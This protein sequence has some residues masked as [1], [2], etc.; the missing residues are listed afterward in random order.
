MAIDVW[1]KELR[2]LREKPER[3]IPSGR[4]TPQV[5]DVWGEELSVLRGREIKSV[6]LW[7]KPTRSFMAGVGDTLKTAGYAVD[8]LGGRG[9]WAKEAG[10]AMIKKW[11]VPDGDPREFEWDNLVDPH[12]L[13]TRIPRALPFS[14]SLVPAALV[15]AAGAVKVG[16]PAL[17]AAGVTKATIAKRPFIKTLLGSLGAGAASRPIESALEAGSTYEMALAKGDTEEEAREAAKETFR[18]NL[19]LAGMDAAQIGLAFTP[20]GKGKAF[21][22]TF[23][24]R[25][26]ATTAKVAGVGSLEA[27]EEIIQDVIQRQALGEEVKWD[28]QMREAAALGAIMGCGLGSAGSVYNVLV[29]KV[30]RNLPLYQQNQIRAAKE[31]LT[32][33]EAQ[34]VEMFELDKVVETE[35]GRGVVEEAVK[36]IL[37][38]AEEFDAEHAIPV[39]RV[40]EMV[41]V[42]VESVAKEVLPAIEPIPELTPEI[43]SEPVIERVPSA[44]EQR[45]LREMLLRDIIKDEVYHDYGR[46][47]KNT[48]NAGVREGIISKEEIVRIRQALRTVSTS[49]SFKQLD[50]M[51]IDEETGQPGF[52]QAELDLELDIRAL[53][54]Q[55]TDT[56]WY[57][58]EKEVQITPPVLER[59]E[60]KLIS[61]ELEPLAREDV[62]HGYKQYL[63]TEKQAINII[64]KYGDKN[65]DVYGSFATLKRRVGKKMPDLD[66]IIEDKSV[67]DDILNLPAN[68]EKI[69]RDI[70]YAKRFNEILEEG[71]QHRRIRNLYDQVGQLTLPEKYEDLLHKLIDAKVHLTFPDGHTVWYKISPDGTLRRIEEALQK[72]HL[73]VGRKPIK[74]ALQDFH[75]QAIKEV[76]PISKELELL[77]V[78]ARK[79]KTA[80][81]FVEAEPKVYHVTDRDFE[82]FDTRQEMRFGAHFSEKKIPVEKIAESVGIDLE[83]AKRIEVVLNVKNPLRL[84][85]LVY[86]EAKDIV[87]ELAKKGIIVPSRDF[88]GSKFWEYSDII[89][90]IKKAGY[91]SI[92]YKNK[93]E[94]GGDSIIAFSPDQIKTKSQLKAFHVQA[95]QEIKPIPKEFEPEKT[96]TGQFNIDAPIKVK[97]GEIISAVILDDGRI[98]YDR[99]AIIHGDVINAI[100]DKFDIT[101]DQVKEGGFIIPEGKFVL[102]GVDAERIARQ[103]KAKKRVKVKRAARLQAF[104]AQAV[105][106]VRPAPERQLAVTATKKK[107]TIAAKKRNVITLFSDI[108]KRGISPSSIRALGYNVRED[109]IEQGLL[110][111]LRKGGMGLDSL[112]TEYIELGW[113]VPEGHEHSSETLVRYLKDP[114]LRKITDEEILGLKSE[115]K[116]FDREYAEHMRGEVEKYEDARRAERDIAKDVAKEV[117]AEAVDKTIRG[118][119]EEVKALPTPAIERE[120]VVP[121]VKEPETLLLAP[122]ELKDRI[123]RRE[124]IVVEP[125]QKLPRQITDIDSPVVYKLLDDSPVLINQKEINKIRGKR[126]AGTIDAKTANQ[127]VSEFKKKIRENAKVEGIAI[128]GGKPVIRKSGVFAP[129]KFTTHNFKDIKG[130]LAFNLDD[131]VLAIDNKTFR[132]I[133]VTGIGP[134]SEIQAAKMQATARLHNFGLEKADKVIKFLKKHNIPINETSGIQAT[135][136]AHG[137]VNTDIDN[138]GAKKAIFDVLIKAD[139]APEVAKQS[140]RIGFL[141]KIRGKE[142]KLIEVVKDGIP[143]NIFN[144]FDADLRPQLNSLRDR[145]NAVRNALG[146]DEIPFRKN[147]GPIIQQTGF[148]SNLRN[149][150]KTTITDNFDF[151]IPNAKKNPH[152]LMRKGGTKDLEWNFWKLLPKYHEAIAQDIFHT[153][154]IEQLK[155]VNTVLQARGD[156]PNAVNFID[157]N[158]RENIV[159]HPGQLDAFFGITKGTKLAAALNSVIRARTTAALAFNIVWTTFIQPAS[160]TLTLGKSVIGMPSPLGLVYGPFDMAKGYIKWITNPAHRAKINKLPTIQ[161]KTGGKSI[162]RTGFGDI[163]ALGTKIMETKWGTLDNFLGQYANVMEYHLTGAAASVGYEM[164]ARQGAIGV[165]A[166]FLADW[167]G[168]STQSRYNRE[169]RPLIQNNLL[170]RANWPFNTFLFELYRLNKTILGRPG[171]MPL[172]G[173]E[174]F[175]VALLLLGGMWLW[176]RFVVEPILGRRLLR[177]SVFVPI[178]GR[179]VE[180]LLNEGIK[181]SGLADKE[182]PIITPVLDRLGLGEDDTV[183]RPA[184]ALYRDIHSF[185]RAVNSWVE[186]ENIQ[187][188]R[189]EMVRWGMGFKGHAGASTL[190]RFVDGLIAN[191]TGYMKSRTGRKLFRIEGL[192][193]YRSVLLGPFATR[194]G[195][196]FRVEGGSILIRDARRELRRLRLLPREQ[197]KFKFNILINQ[198]P[199]LARQ[200]NILIE[201][202]ANPILAEVR[203][204]GIR[205]GMRAERIVEELEKLSA[206]RRRKEFQKLIDAGVVTERVSIQVQTIMEE[207][208]NAVQGILPNIKD[209]L[210]SDKSL[211]RIIFLYARAIGTDPITALNRMLA[212]ERIIRITGGAII[213]ERMTVEESQKIRRQR[214]LELGISPQELITEWRLDHIIPKGL[215]GSDREDNL[216]LVST[217]EWETY[218]PVEHHLIRLLKTGKI[219]R[220][221]AQ[222]LIKKFKKGM[223]SAS[224]ILNLK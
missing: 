177:P 109:F 71:E 190:N 187:P 32:G 88:L 81:E 152:A 31:G 30:K 106:E 102:A 4:F 45:V 184:G 204:L 69:K 123:K 224:D 151:V 112:A 169:A 96:G 38:L 217:E 24:R 206:K 173:W 159:G 12:W 213:T 92:I 39:E 140:L 171:G 90:A 220:R 170:M 98:F 154:I 195:I 153:P 135:L 130:K 27:G 52:E 165:T 132:E 80:E 74:Q 46:F 178:V 116:K 160:Q 114:K 10:R 107:S 162:G 64:N 37:S 87:N 113:I 97:E 115:E 210:W 29:E 100:E 25:V 48:A 214:A 57:A 95:I 207:Q 127:R 185:I 203:G 216:V 108:A 33:I 42:P 8:F 179:E 131:A 59:P 35:E 164:A 142:S 89:S 193:R 73:R 149:V 54:K 129:E 67:L 176:D 168:G 144:L 189:K 161:T 62:K 63:E 182:I 202:E 147:Y 219:E 194:A 16:V 183:L 201:D 85:D 191:S 158:I 117:E 56:I 198:F 9:D 212:G 65:I 72:E 44:F 21:T 23:A 36:K 17:V 110:R 155:A 20:I 125:F 82:I 119:Q 101:A 180:V 68:R 22:K 211:I 50:Q 51:R 76:K 121:P 196:E 26:A 70:A 78:R 43:I 150:L 55:L 126:L 163:D 6:P 2:V 133:A 148:W 146:K 111:I 75:V 53:A 218:T 167:M 60:V 166:D 138:K 86:W 188:L 209:K 192:D 199:E 134:L 124:K 200:V 221:K 79:F 223:I 83:K 136:V 197:A 139:I 94:G 145:A 19:S 15:G 3:V 137:L 118:V 93:I 49:L 66:I 18:R 14:L 104:H 141:Q 174:R 208:N 58:S 215:G 175:N 5:N 41:E 11:E 1:E 77:T 91:D 222:R 172:G 156:V 122:I 47:W 61:K 105:K 40:G 84:P 7:K 99:K 28:P 157:R 128:V 181:A 143:N 120:R 186:H 205:N 103:A 13:S 34:N